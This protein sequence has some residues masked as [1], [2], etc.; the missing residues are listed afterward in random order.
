MLVKAT[1]K[2]TEQKFEA[3]LQGLYDAP[4]FDGSKYEPGKGW[5]NCHTHKGIF[6]A[7]LNIRQGCRI[8]YSDQSGYYMD[9]KGLYY[10]MTLDQLTRLFQFLALGDWKPTPS[11]G[12]S[13][14]GSWHG[15]PLRWSKEPKFDLSLVQ[16]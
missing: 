2:M 4:V 6:R 8:E 7:F 13:C 11:V 1:D 5:V 15:K 3:I 9:C 12:S 10:E 16:V 14:Y